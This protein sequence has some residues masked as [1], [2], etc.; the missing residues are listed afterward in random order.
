MKC[1]RPNFLPD[2]A[3]TPARFQ[4]V[5]LAKSGSDRILKVEIWYVRIETHY[6]NTDIETRQSMHVSV[7]LEYLEQTDGQTTLR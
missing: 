3:P 7:S 5:N 2:P 4:D 1:S 6:G